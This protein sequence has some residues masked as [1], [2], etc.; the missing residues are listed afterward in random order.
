MQ[1]D[2][3]SVTNRRQTECAKWD[4]APLI[5]GSQDILPMWVADMDFSIAEPINDALKKRMN[6]KIYGY[7]LPAYPSLTAA[8]INRIH[9]KY[10]WEVA[11]EWIVLT[12]GVVAALFAAVKA[13]TKPGDSVLHQGPVYYPFWSSIEDNGCHVANNQLVLNGDRYEIN[14]DDFEAHFKTKM[15]LRPSPSRV[16][17]MI[18]C[19]PHNPVGRVWNRE[20]LTRMGEIVIKHNALMIADEIHCELLLNGAEHIPFATISKEFEIKSI[21]CMAASKTFNLAGLEASVIIIPDKQTR[22]KFNEARAGIMGGVNTF[23]LVA[24]EAAFDH[25]DEWLTQL[26]AYLQNNL[27]FLTD[28]FQNHIPE[29]KV[30]Q[31]EG[32]YLVWLDCRKLGLDDMALRKFM[33]EKAKIGMDDGYLFGPSGTGFQRMNIACPRETLTE[34]MRRMESAV[35]T[36]R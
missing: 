29:I 1:Y 30:I 17:M 20:E 36:L 26:L 24:L 23:G 11:P 13:Y 15:D 7:N 9:R 32:T 33:R 31:P 19:N 18:M 3:D 21:T 10:G 16:R 22:R 34:A 12:P 28:Y 6:H 25:G 27:D 5:F 35:K 4:A 2:F 14:F 8:I